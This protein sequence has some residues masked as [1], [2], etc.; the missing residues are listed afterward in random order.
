MKVETENITTS[1]IS[2]I[3]IFIAQSSLTPCD[4]LD[5]SPPGSPT[6]GILQARILGVGCHSLLQAIFPTLGSNLG[7]PYFRQIFFYCL[8]R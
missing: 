6:Y 2:Y 7:L 5:C 3:Y 8:S 4:P 1:L